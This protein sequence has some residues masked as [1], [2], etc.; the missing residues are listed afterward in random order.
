VVVSATISGTILADASKPYAAIAAL[1]AAIASS[2]DF[3]PNNA[4]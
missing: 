2:T 3:P 4:A 1:P